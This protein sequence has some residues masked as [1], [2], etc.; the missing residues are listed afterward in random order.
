MDSYVNGIVG[1]FKIQNKAD[2]MQYA[3]NA[4]MQWKCGE[5]SKVDYDEAKKLFDFICD[6]VEFPADVNKLIADELHNMVEVLTK[7]Q[8]RQKTFIDQLFNGASHAQSVEDDALG[9]DAVIKPRC[10]NDE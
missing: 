1:D 5:T 6:N 10:N 2:A 3:I 7:Q 9:P 4:T 8:N